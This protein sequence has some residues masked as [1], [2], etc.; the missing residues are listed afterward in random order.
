MAEPSLPSIAATHD[1]GFVYV[2][3][4]ERYFREAS[5]GAASLRRHN[6][7]VRICLVTDRVHGA[8]FWDDLVMLENPAFGFRDKLAMRR[9]P[10]GHAVF[11]DTD[12]TV[13]GDLSSLFVLL[14][15]YDVCGVQISE[16]QDYE[17][18]GGIPAAFPEMNSGMI[19]FRAGAATAEFF[20]LWEKFYDQFLALNSGDRYHYANVGDQKSLR[21]A[22][23]HS[24]VRHTVVGAEFNFIPFRLEL[25]SLPVAVLHTRATAGLDALAGRLNARLGRR[26]Y[27]PTLDTVVADAMSGTEARRLLTA[28][29]RLCLRMVARQIM[30]LALRNQFR[31]LTGLRAWLVG[32]R[33][34]SPDHGPEA[35]WK[36]PAGKP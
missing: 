16:G 35:K 14:T 28:S 29:L 8:P 2:A 6:P 19:G 11:L 31:R 26:A 12:T 9:A 30:P 25:A 15:R 36:N 22:L 17:M 32:N 10:Y 1:R 20:A 13:C 7:T 4:G 21:A 27:V 18:D 34:E 24:A 23:W 5:A 33:H 3:T